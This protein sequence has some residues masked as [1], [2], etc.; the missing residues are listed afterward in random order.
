MRDEDYQMLAGDME[1]IADQMRE[2]L[3]DTRQ[4]VRNF[5]RLANAVIDTVQ[6]LRA[7]NTDDAMEV[8]VQT[9]GDV[10][11]T[12]YAN[13]YDTPQWCDHFLREEE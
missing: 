6:F 13:D 5:S 4:L 2:Y 9:L 10:G 7:G 8:C 11:N 1:Q 3:R 12:G